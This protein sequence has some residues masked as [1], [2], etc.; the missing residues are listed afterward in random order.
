MSEPAS[1]LELDRA[2]NG[3]APHCVDIEEALVERLDIP[4]THDNRLGSTIITAACMRNA[5]ELQGKTLAL[6]LRGW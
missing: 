4:V 1:S 5:M 3:A 6:S 2:T